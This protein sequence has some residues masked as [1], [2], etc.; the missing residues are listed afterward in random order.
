MGYYIRRHVGCDR[1]GTTLL[2]AIIN[3][4][5]GTKT[6]DGCSAGANCGHDWRH[7]GEHLFH[8]YHL[9]VRDAFSRPPGGWALNRT[10]FFLGSRSLDIPI[11]K[12]FPDESVLYIFLVAWSHD[13]VSIG[14]TAD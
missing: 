10:R 11:H 7:N 6:I 12:C 3:E 14:R 8:A 13:F 4:H 1:A 9:S 5:D 2:G